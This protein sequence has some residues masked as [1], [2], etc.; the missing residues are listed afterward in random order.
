MIFTIDA[1]IALGIFLSSTLLFY[2]FF[3][4]SGGF[5]L[6]SPNLYSA[7]GNYFGSYDTNN[8]L[9]GG[10][11][12]PGIYSFI[13]HHYQLNNVSFTEETLQMVIEAF[14]FPANVK[15]S[16]WDGTNF[17]KILE[18]NENFFE[19]KMSV[20]RYLVLDFNRG[21]STSLNLAQ[22]QPVKILA[23]KNATYEFNMTNPNLSDSNVNVE[24]IFSN[25]THT[26]DY[27]SPSSKAV[28]IP[29]SS[30]TTISFDISI[31]EGAVIDEYYLTASTTGD[32]S[33]LSNTSA[34]IIKFGLLEVET[35]YGS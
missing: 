10:N 5:G 33:D 30:T 32:F 1:I 3:T 11:F 24:L 18:K 20:K 31:P 2:S 15:I 29:G 19:D 27:V 7:A 6:R 16:I 23:G 12:S 35:G 13:Y 34:S 21:L 28:T 26:F 22:M 8:A 9:F 25:S 14:E 17:E 4:D